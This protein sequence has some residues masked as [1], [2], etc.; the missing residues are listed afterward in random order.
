[1]SL[2]LLLWNETNTAFMIVCIQSPPRLPMMIDQ[3]WLTSR[4]LLWTG[5]GREHCSLDFVYKGGRWIRQGQCLTKVNILRLAIGYRYAMTKR[6]TQNT[7]PE[8]GTKGLAKLG[9]PVGW[10]LQVQVWPTKMQWVRWL[11]GSRT[12]LHCVCSLN[13]DRWRITWPCC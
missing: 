5:W 9:K 7:E 13:L 6:N 10:R 11:D 2:S 3:N 8:I 1:M 4:W 12:A